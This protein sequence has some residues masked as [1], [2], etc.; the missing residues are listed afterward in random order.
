MQKRKSFGPWQPKQPNLLLP[1][2]REWLSEDY[3]VYILMDLVDEF[4]LS[5]ILIPTQAKDHRVEK[6]FDPRMMTLLLL[7][8]YCVGTV[9]S[10]KIERACYEDLAFRVLTGNQQPDHSRISEFR[11]L[12]LDALKG[13]FIQILRLCQKA[14]MM[15]LGN[16]ALVGIKVQA[17]ASKHKAIAAAAQEVDAAAA[18]QVELNRG[19][20]ATADKAIAATDKAIEAAETAGV[21]PPD[22][23]PLKSDAMTRR[24]LARKADGTP[25][26]KTQRNFPDPDCYLM[27]SGSLYL[28]AYNCQLSVDSDNQ[29][30]VA[31][32][33]SKQ[34]PDVEHLEPM[35]E[36]IAGS[37]A[38]MPAVM[39]IDAGYWCEDN[40]R[41]C[42]NQG[43]YTSIAIGRLQHGKTPPPMRRPMPRG[44]GS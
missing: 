24:G 9:S 22:L 26:A 5:E 1:S 8:G 44:A 3:Q 7:Y 23:A 16:V 14:G 31:L 10:R 32:G 2:P 41:A 4:D 37:A 42:S 40:A 38:A 13:L 27:Q 12:N 28:Q 43:N 30:I 18:E 11:R 34:P 35:L 39:T 15:S 21:E 19:A 17:N 25:M 6:G 33:V 20:E 29:V 36:R